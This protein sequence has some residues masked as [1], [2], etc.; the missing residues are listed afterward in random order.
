MKATLCDSSSENREEAAF[1][2]SDKIAERKKRKKKEKS[3]EDEITRL[4]DVPGRSKTSGALFSSSF[5]S[6]SK[7][8]RQ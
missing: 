5:L 2:A 1:E 8:K 4:R 6:S 3:G 7:L